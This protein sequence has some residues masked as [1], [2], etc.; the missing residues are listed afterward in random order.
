MRTYL[1]FGV[2]CHTPLPSSVQYSI[3]PAASYQRPMTTALMDARALQP[4]TNRRGT[5]KDPVISQWSV[6]NH[7]SKPTQPGVIGQDAIC[8]PEASHHH[9]GTDIWFPHFA[10]QS[11]IKQDGAQMLLSA[12]KQC[13]AACRHRMPA[14]TCTTQLF[15][16]IKR[17]D[18][19][20]GWRRGR[21][22][23]D[24]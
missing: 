1:C 17:D 16:S 21:T 15:H 4:H 6:E 7:S 23:L 8:S 22:W 13:G 2:L 3:D 19:K 24:E 12:A 18:R 11:S 10:C 5:V 14:R 9:R 20:K